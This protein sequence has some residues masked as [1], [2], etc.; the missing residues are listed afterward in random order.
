M[1]PIP[2]Q[3]AINALLFN[4]PFFAGVLLRQEIVA[5]DKIQ[6]AAVNGKTLKYNP[7]YIETLR[8][9][10][11]VGLLAHEVMHL[12][13]LHHTRMKGRDAEKWNKATD[14]VIN[15]TLIDEGFVLPS[16]ALLSSAYNGKSAEEVYRL[17]PDEPKGGNGQG[18]GDSK[19]SFGE[20]E[21]AEGDAQ[22]AEETAKV[23]TKQAEAQAKACGKLPAFLERA[24]ANAPQTLDWQETLARFVQETVQRDSNWQMPSR[25]LLSQGLILPGLYS[26]APGNIVFAADT[27]GS[28]REEDISKVCAELL[29]AIQSIA[30]QGSEAEL[31]AI[32]C[33]S[34]VQ[35]VETLT[36]ND[37]PKPKGGG[38]TDFRPPFDYIQQH[39]IAPCALVYFTDGDCYSFPT[40]PSYPVLWVCIGNYRTFNPP[41]GE[42][43]KTDLN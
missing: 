12:T 26:K 36:A 23:Q 27:S 34:A 13:L 1:H 38:G 15:Q 18:K 22:E 28:M 10:E 6:T 20:V 35:H 37:T 8:H 29:A 17:L 4:Q 32:Y 11:I 7:E 3:K 9:E 43:I 40:E 19:P 42:V 41:F 21:E 31:L 2:L 5:T 39:G 33:D 16:G 14:Y 24:I 30:E 25:R